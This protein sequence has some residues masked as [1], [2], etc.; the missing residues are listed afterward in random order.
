MP[1]LWFIVDRG[2]TDRLEVAMTAGAMSEAQGKTI[3]VQA[4]LEYAR[5]AV[6][7]LRSLRI[8]HSTMRYAE[9]PT[10]IGLKSV[11]DAWQPWH[12]QQIRDILNLVA[13]TERQ[14]GKNAGTDPLQLSG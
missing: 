11:G 4:R 3:D 7:V 6:A 13:A 1:S 9:L 10:A 14:A 8:A 5:A 2:R 12:R